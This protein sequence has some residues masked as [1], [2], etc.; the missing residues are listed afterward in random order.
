MEK[1]VIVGAGPSGL[2]LAHYLL[3]K[4]DRY[5]VEIYERLGD[6]TEVALSNSRTIPYSLNERGFRALRPIDGLEDAVK[7]GCVE[8]CMTAFHTVDGKTQL[9]PRK[10]PIFH[11]N[12]ISLVTTLLSSL[13]AMAE[14]GD[15]LK[16][17][18]NCKCIGVD[19]DR[20]TILFES[21]SPEAK[22][23]LEPLLVTYD[24]LVGADGAR[25]SVRSQFLK[26]PFFDFEQTTLG[27]CYKTI[28]FP[29]KNS[30]T[31]GDIKMKAFHVWRA[32]EG[33]NFTASPQIS[34][35]YIGV[36]FVPRTRQD[37]LN[38][39]SVAQVKEFFRQYLREVNLLLSDAEAENFMK[40]PIST[41][42]VVTFSWIEEYSP[43]KITL[44]PGINWALWEPDNYGTG[45]SSSTLPTLLQEL[46]RLQ[47]TE[48][49]AGMLD[50]ERIILGGHSAGG[51]MAMENAD[52][53]FFPQVA[54]AF[55]Y[56]TSAA[57]AASLGHEPGKILPLP[58]KLP[59]L[60]MGGTSDV[61]M[62]RMAKKYG[63]GFDPLILLEYTFGQ[64]I[65]GG[66]EDSYLLILK[67]AQHSTIS[68]PFDLTQVGISDLR[69][70]QSEDKIRD[71]MAEAIGLFI[72]A[73]V[74]QQPTALRALNELLDPANPL[75]ASVERK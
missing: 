1:V 41:Q 32:S 47:S 17:H 75:I 4:G 69:R 37:M 64:A 63:L 16:L 70:T 48:P 3:R 53:R 14:G 11:T 28:F 30:E 18:F 40:R 65:S 10:Q 52:P 50:L 38:F 59:L 68:H 72:D 58:D 39:A 71:L 74:R 29:S 9:V 20:Q 22:A 12:R 45:P 26:T 51:R 15:R 21:V 43:G 5:Q 62:A 61:I 67:G 6:P 57:V 36:V 46:E 49:L 19:F 60:L 33:I 54:G 7:A 44:T 66:R 34:G 31:G 42:V 8:N 24:R 55:A 2:L 35:G 13:V 56:G 27:R 73:H 23:E 25:S